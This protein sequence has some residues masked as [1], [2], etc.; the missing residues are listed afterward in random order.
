MVYG[1]QLRL[2][3]C[4]GV[5]ILISLNVFFVDALLL[6]EHFCPLCDIFFLEVERWKSIVIFKH[7]PCMF[8]GGYIL[9]I[10]KKIIL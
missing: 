6:E 5:S 4:V 3:F 10:R 8:T 7:F 2:I 1:H 9:M